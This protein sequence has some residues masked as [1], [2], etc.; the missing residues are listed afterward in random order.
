MQKFFLFFILFSIFTVFTSCGGDNTQN[1]NLV[2]CTS[3]IDCNGG[4]CGESGTCVVYACSPNENTCLEDG[5]TAKVCK[6]DRSGFEE[7]PCG[8]RCNKGLYW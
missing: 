1:G 3:D 8:F 6:D 5:K 7:I 2:K 4:V